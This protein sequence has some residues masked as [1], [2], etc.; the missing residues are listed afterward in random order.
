MT[1]NPR[2]NLTIQQFLDATRGQ[3]IRMVKQDIKT[4]VR[5]KRPKSK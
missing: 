4:D 2:P 3:R 1:P 5:P